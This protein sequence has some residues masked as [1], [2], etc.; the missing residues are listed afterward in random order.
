MDGFLSTLFRLAVDDAKKEG[1]VP[2]PI[3]L[4]ALRRITGAAA[5]PLSD[6]DLMVIYDGE[7][8]PYVQRTTQGCSTR[9]GTSA[10]P[11]ALRA[12]LPISWPWR[13]PTSPLAP[14]CRRRATW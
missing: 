7:M 5:G 10:S 8:V 11:W 13:A 14:P 3:V 6:L 4:V 1:A 9:C 2:A 12:G